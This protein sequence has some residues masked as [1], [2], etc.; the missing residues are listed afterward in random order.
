MKKFINS[1]YFQIGITA[2]LVIAA[3]T[4]LC[5]ALLNVKTLLNFLG[6]V[7]NIL[8][9][10][11]VG[12]VLAYIMGPIV[13][14]FEK[15]VFNKLGKESIKRNLSILCTLV[16][17]LGIFIAIISVVIPQL[18]ESLQ[19]LIISVPT[20]FTNIGDWIVDFVKSNNLEESILNN[21]DNIT[22]N[23]LD[24]VN[25]IVIPSDTGIASM[26]SSGIT[27]VIKF[28]F[29]LVIGIVFAIYILANTSKFKAQSRKFLYS[30][31][32]VEKVNNFLNELSHVNH[33]F[34]NFIG[35][36]IGDSTCVAL[37]T[38]IFLLVFKYP[39]PLLI[40]VLIGITDLIPYFGPYIGTIPS[41]LLILMVS[42]IKAVTFILFIIVLQQLD[43]NLI[44]P[45]IQK[46]ATG[47]PSFWVLFAITLF[48]GLFGIIGLLIAV[49]CFTIIYELVTEHV[50]RRL[51]HKMLPTDTN[52]YEQ[53]ELPKPKIKK[54]KKIIK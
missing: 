48:G 10:L 33:I 28:I 30:I 46:Q 44:T 2:F 20:Y 5:F 39:Y 4:L 26:V 25:K 41:A 15:K 40:A 52:Y 34:L 8:M 7:I 13:N 50:N 53:K 23:V 27:G 54:S 3:S 11:I 36:K 35:G 16:I 29:N 14:L 45:K 49:P 47:L 24:V 31:F 22:K 19:K 1:K 18:L 43:G 6:M 42:P 17:I 12:L 32:N 51:E 9:P 38:F 37:L 21:F